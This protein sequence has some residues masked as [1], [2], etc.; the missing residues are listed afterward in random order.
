M[1]K[2]KLEKERENSYQK[3]KRSPEE[4]HTQI[5]RNLNDIF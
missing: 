4:W 5:Y 1:D 3:M 2:T